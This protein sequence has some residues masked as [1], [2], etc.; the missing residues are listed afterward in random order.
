MGEFPAKGADAQPMHARHLRIFLK[1]C[2]P[3]GGQKT[4]HEEELSR[5]NQKRYR[6]SLCSVLETLVQGMIN[7][8]PVTVRCLHESGACCSGFA[9]AIRQ[10]AA[11]CFL[12]TNVLGTANVTF[13]LPQGGNSRQKSKSFVV[14]A[15]QPS[16]RGVQGSECTVVC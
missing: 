2:V 3:F 4:L 5:L 8:I 9:P 11:R 1:P 14:H 7:T 16:Q 6:I 15:G 12:A 13:R 10:K